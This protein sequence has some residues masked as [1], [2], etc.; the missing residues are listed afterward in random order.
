MVSIRTHPQ[1][2]SFETPHA[3]FTLPV[4]PHR[5]L[6]TPLNAYIRPHPQVTK[7]APPMAAAPFCRVGDE[8]AVHERWMAGRGDLTRALRLRHKNALR[9]VAAG[10][11][12]AGE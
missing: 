1:G 2:T 9:R 11:G 4:T 10:S 8:A 3:Y 12:R 5:M 6:I 7:S